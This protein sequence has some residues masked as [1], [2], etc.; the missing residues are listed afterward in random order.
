MIEENLP[1][2][3]EKN[4]SLNVA[5]IHNSELD[6]SNKNYNSSTQLQENINTTHQFVE[7]SFKEMKNTCEPSF[8]KQDN[9]NTEGDKMFHCT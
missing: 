2:Y 3:T 1:N 7:F 8:S 4:L 6:S 5:P 9:I